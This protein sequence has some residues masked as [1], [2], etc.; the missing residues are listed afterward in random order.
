MPFSPTDISSLA[1]WLDAADLSTITKDGS[2]VVTAW[3]DKSGNGNDASSAGA[4]DATYNATGLNN[5]PA[6]L[7]PDTAYLSVADD[8]SLNY[9][10]C[11][12]FAVVQ[13]DVDSGVFQ[14]CVQKFNA[15]GNQREWFIGS[16]SGTDVF[17]GQFST[18]GSAVTAA[19][20]AVT[21]TIGEAFI[22]DFI[23]DATSKRLSV[24]GA[25]TATAA[26]TT[27]FNGTADFEIGRQGSGG[28]WQG[29]VSE[30]LFFTDALSGAEYTQV[31]NYLTNKWQGALELEIH[32]VAPW[33]L[34]ETV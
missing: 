12:M 4:A 23:A 10:Y 24:N 5:R 19:T 2:N 8:V 16:S 21:V 30:V 26:Q 14:G 22:V 17:Q 9:T 1:I 18:D 15:T 7:L 29:R 6:I 11:T 3:A 27:S 33:H 34:Y 32:K 20:T 25:G 13:R 28:Y 31:I